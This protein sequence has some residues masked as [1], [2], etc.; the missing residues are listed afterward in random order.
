MY[1]DM[2][3]D[4]MATNLRCEKIFEDHTKRIDLHATSLKNI[5]VQL[6]QLTQTVQATNNVALQGEKGQVMSSRSSQE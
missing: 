1:I 5:E 6:G 4:I 2:K 3:V